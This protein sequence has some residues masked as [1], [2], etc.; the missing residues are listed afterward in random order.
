[1]AVAQTPTITERSQKFLSALDT[2]LASKAQY[3]FNDDERFNWHF[4]P[5]KRNGLS[6]RDMSDTQRALAFSLLR[7]SLSKTG[8]QKATT[9]ISLENVLREVEGR[10][11]NDTYRDPLN[12]YC[13]VFGKPDAASWGWR[14]EGHHISLNVVVVDGAIQSET[15]SFFGSNPAVIQQGQERGAAALKLEMELGF[16]LVNSLSSAQ[17]KTALLSENA[18]SEIISFDSR[19]ATPLQP[20]G[21]SL[22]QMNATQQT[23]F[24]QLLDTYVS[25]YELGFSKTLMTKITKAGV[26]NL[27]FAWAGGKKFGEGH[28]YRIQGP[29]LL[30]EY[31]N[32]QN[33]GNHIHTAVRDL[34]NDFGE[35]ILREHYQKEHT[36]K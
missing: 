20:Q 24:L 25:N 15:P 29:M 3:T 36:T 26:E 10:G 31:D 34:T 11:N 1:M 18:L 9:I 19:K 13:T 2:A 30:I 28:Y 14:F 6:L 4:V 7:Q 35:D 27:Y 5:R 16:Q 32:T 8:Y 21:I 12:Y 22:A 23:I 33:N 17:L